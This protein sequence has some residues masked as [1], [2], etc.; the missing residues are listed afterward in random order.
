MA[1][2]TWC[3]AEI[4]PGRVIQIEATN[5]STSYRIERVQH[6]GDTEEGG[7]SVPLL[8]ALQTIEGVF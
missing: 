3:N 4:R 2:E 7:K 6:T 8:D 5:L 1:A